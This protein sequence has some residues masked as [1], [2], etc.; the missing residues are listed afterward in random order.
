MTPSRKVPCACCLHTQA[1]PLTHPDPLL[2][3]L[4]VQSLVS[5]DSQAP[6]VKGP[7][8][9]SALSFPYF[10]ANCY[11]FPV[12]VSHLI[13]SHSSSSLQAYLL[14][15]PSLKAEALPTTA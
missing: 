11:V 15:Q 4:P 13:T 14:L 1:F 3:S 6:L 10:S 7:W 8:R 2:R 9:S 5:R 12:E